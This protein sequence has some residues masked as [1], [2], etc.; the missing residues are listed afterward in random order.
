MT[1]EYQCTSPCAG[2]QRGN[3]VT[4][5]VDGGECVERF[6]EKICQT[7]KGLGPSGGPVLLNIDAS[8]VECSR[9]LPTDSHPTKT[10][11]F[12]SYDNDEC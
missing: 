11:Y 7:G 5:G 12:E 9:V 3:A 1:L 4:E 2:S 10:K 6:R 8:G